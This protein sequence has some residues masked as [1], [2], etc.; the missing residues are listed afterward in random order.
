[1]HYY[2]YNE[3][4]NEMKTELENYKFDI[5]LVC[6]LNGSDQLSENKTN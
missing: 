1:M 5:N 2:L 4:R 6:L 3:I